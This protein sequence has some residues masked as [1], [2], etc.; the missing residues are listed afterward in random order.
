MLIDLDHILADPIFSAT[1]CSIG[2]HPLH[3]YFAIGTFF[4]MFLIKKMRIIA[5]GLLLHIVTDL[6]DCIWMA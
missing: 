2:Y 1:R 6:V 4:V 3:S 5:T